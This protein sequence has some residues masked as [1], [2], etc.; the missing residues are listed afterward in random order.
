MR[1][2]D[3]QRLAGGDK[4]FADVFGAQGHVGTVFAVEHQGKG[5]AVLEAQQYQGGEAFRV[6][7]DAADI[8]AFAGQGFDQEAPHVVVPTRLSIADLRPSRAVPK[9]ILAEEPPRYLAKLDTS[10]SRAPTCCA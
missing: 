6:D 9:A 7:L 3:Q 4:G 1:A 10:S 2:G 5:F 8:A